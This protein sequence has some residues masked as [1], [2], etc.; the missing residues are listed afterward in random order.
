MSKS[1]LEELGESTEDLAEG[2]SKYAKE[3]KALTGFD[4][5]IDDTH[6]K[7]LYDIMEGI[8]GVWDKL[9]DTQQARVAEI[10]GGT[11]QLQVISS[12][13]GNWSDAARSGY[14]VAQNCLG[15][16]YHYGRANEQN[17]QKALKWWRRAAGQGYGNAEN[18][19][20]YMYFNG[21]IVYRDY[22]QAKDWFTKAAE[23]GDSSASENLSLMEN[24]DLASLA[25]PDIQP[26]LNF[27]YITCSQMEDFVKLYEAGKAEAVEE[28]EEEQS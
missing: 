4:I 10:L 3:I 9:S 2:F 1:D 24:S 5:M 23:H 12:I 28:N 26:L 6:F 17:D 11:R 27:Q 8:A 16:C 15:Y 25:S 19:L 18:A 14:A 7:D 22:A 13:I 21:I 20:G